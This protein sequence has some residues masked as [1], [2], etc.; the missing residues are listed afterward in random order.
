MSSLVLFTHVATHPA[1]SAVTAAGPTAQSSNRGAATLIALVVAIFL[2][3]WSLTVLRQALVPF[4][5]M[6]RVMAKTA[7]VAVLTT[8]A[9]VALMFALLTR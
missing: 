3:G 7:F 6:V 1:V 5:E 9:F 2:I 4:F 8:G